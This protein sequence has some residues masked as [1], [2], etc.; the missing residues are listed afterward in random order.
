M[1][2]G[3]FSRLWTSPGQKSEPHFTQTICPALNF[4]VFDILD[5][6]AV[7][8]LQH[9]KTGETEKNGTG[10]T[11]ADCE[12]SLFANFC[13]PTHVALNRPNRPREYPVCERQVAADP[14]SCFYFE[15]KLFTGKND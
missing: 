9:L 13:N 12:D 7:V 2:L 11:A 6:A 14:T 3:S 1:S 8:Q 4:G 15:V 5:A 10:R